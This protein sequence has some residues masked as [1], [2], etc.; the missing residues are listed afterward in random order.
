M[1]RRFQDRRLRDLMEHHA[2]HRHLRFQNL[3]KVPCNSLTLAVG[4]CGQV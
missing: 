3:Q 4:V 2:A 1:L